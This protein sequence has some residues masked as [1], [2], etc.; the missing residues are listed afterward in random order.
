MEENTRPVNGDFT[1][2]DI[3]LYIKHFFVRIM[4]RGILSIIIIFAVAILAWLLLPYEMRY[5]TEL[6]NT[7]KKTGAQVY[8]YPNGRAFNNHDVISPTVTRDIYDRMKLEDK[9]PYT[10]FAELFYID[11]SNF[12]LA[13]LDAEYETK[14]ARKNISTVSLNLLEREYNLKKQQI[15]DDIFRINM[16][17]HDALSKDECIQILTAIPETW[18]RIYSKTEAAVLPKVE[19]DAWK[20]DFAGSMKAK[21]GNLII[22]EKARIYCNLLNISCDALQSMMDGKNIALESGEYLEDIKRKLEHI[23]KFQINVFSQYVIMSSGLFTQYDQIFLLRS[24]KMTDRQLMQVEENIKYAIQ[25]LE[26]IRSSAPVRES[27][28]GASLTSKTGNTTVNLEFNDNV[29]SQISELIRNDVTN[30]VRR[31]VAQKII[32]YGEQKAAIV[33]EKEYIQ[34]LINTQKAKTP[35]D[36]LYSA[37]EFRSRMTILQNE[38]LDTAQKIQQFRT[39]ITKDYLNARSFYKPASNKVK[40]RKDYI[41]PVFKVVLGLFALCVIYNVVMICL[42]FKFK[43]QR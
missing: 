14:L 11:N 4:V 34:D 8:V 42:D 31:D 38:L 2:T 1:L 30:T 41:L 10:D 20:R 9:L 16:K 17:P 3:L 22:L 39:K 25:A 29:L 12:K 27:A 26:L 35:I 40:V 7:L 23:N 37:S 21:E 15:A 43:Y 33:A 24:L 19:L 36:E 18:Y 28:S 5:Y 6:E 13:R 32:A